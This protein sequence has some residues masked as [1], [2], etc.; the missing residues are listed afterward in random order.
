MKKIL[1]M[2]ILVLLSI[3][4]VSSSIIEAFPANA[5]LTWS[6]NPQTTQ[7]ISW[8]DTVDSADAAIE[9][10]DNDLADAP[11]IA[12]VVT[13]TLSAKNGA[14]KRF[15]GTLTEL[16][17]GHRYN[18][19][20]VDSNKRSPLRSF[21]TAPLSPMPFDFLVFGDSQSVNY[22]T[23]GN[24]LH[25]AFNKYPGAAFFSNVGD[26]VDIGDDYKQ[27]FDWLNNASDII[28]HIPAMPVSGNHEDYS[29]TGKNTRA[30]GFR[31][32]FTL[33]HNG[34]DELNG[35][36]Y[37]CD[38]SN[39]HFVMLD[40]QYPEEGAFTP[41]MIKNQQQWLE[42]DL[43][44]TS[45]TWKIVFMH[46]PLYSH[47]PARGDDY[48]RKCFAPLFEKYHVDIVFNGHD[49]VYARSFPLVNSK[50]VSADK[51]TVYVASG[52]SGTKSYPLVMASLGIDQ[53]FYNPTDQPNY[54]TVSIARNVLTLKAFKAD[55]TE[56]DSSLMRK[57]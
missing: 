42:K 18:Y 43:S 34:P 47:T 11:T 8:L 22:N 49:H 29:V 25:T 31:Q 20:I 27:W 15:S 19:R 38:Y 16:L 26:L 5:A 14:L 44:G 28:D 32:L 2:I 56:L 35:L 36:A 55:G 6:D 3:P 46:R 23:W 53:T 41:D 30:N 54:I 51:G 17:P 40:T 21:M 7:T 13:T 10:W 24:T 57:Y 1:G 50:P 9:Y 39:A 52:R 37:S 33:P 45:A 4:L 12:T 48:L